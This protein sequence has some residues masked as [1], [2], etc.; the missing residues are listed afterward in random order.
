[1]LDKIQKLYPYL[2]IKNINSIR[3]DDK[4][5]QN[6]FIASSDTDEYFVKLLDESWK[7]ESLGIVVNIQKYD[8][9]IPK[10]YKTI[11]DKFVFDFNNKEYFIQDFIKE[12][13]F[14]K[15]NDDE[16]VSFGETLA[17][18]HLLTSKIDHI[19]PAIEGFEGMKEQLE[20]KFERNS[21]F[22][23]IELKDHAKYLFKLFE[24]LKESKA[25]TLC[26]GEFTSEHVYFNKGKVSAVIDWDGVGLDNKYFDFG[27]AVVSLFNNQNFDIEKFNIFSNSYHKIID[28][29]ENS[30]FIF[31]AMLYGVSK[32][33]IW[34]LSDF[35]IK[36]K[37]LP[38]NQYLM[39]RNL[40]ENK[41]RIIKI[42]E[43][44]SSDS[45]K[46]CFN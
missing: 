21:K 5:L 24:D 7:K 40:I 37:I 20:D 31:N 9:P 14:Q 8:Y 18:L 45:Q 32:F 17:K 27:T 43:K 30:E 22:L 15:M 16:V 2:N 41:K 38:I 3:R 19:R 4:Y 11:D 12:K 25:D 44:S 28:Y 35:F 13:N 36:Q 23:N 42:F 34:G 29:K 1:M 46:Q 33:F 6:L 10:I 39:Y 26:H